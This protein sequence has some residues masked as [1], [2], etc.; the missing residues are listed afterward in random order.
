ML[1][2][3]GYIAVYDTVCKP[4]ISFT[5]NTLSSRKFSVPKILIF[6]KGKAY[7]SHLS[8]DRLRCYE[9]FVCLWNLNSKICLNHDEIRH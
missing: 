5:S 7:F 1:K 3:L 4:S 2:K 8:I 9:N 6:Q